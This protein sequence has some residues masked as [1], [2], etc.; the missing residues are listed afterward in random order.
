ML[1]SCDSN[2]RNYISSGWTRSAQFLVLTCFAATIIWGLSLGQ[3]LWKIKIDNQLSAT[4]I[5]NTAEYSFETTDHSSVSIQGII[6]P[7]ITRELKKYL[8][9]KPT[10]ELINLN[11]TGGNIFEARGIAKLIEAKKL[12]THVLENCF[13]SCTTVFIAGQKRTLAH[14]AK[15][16]FHQYRVNSNKLFAPNVN[17]KKELDKDIATFRKQG[18]SQT[19]LDRAFLR[20]HTDMWFPD[21]SDLIEA[22]VIN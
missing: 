12:N 3:L 5:K 7:G 16:G 19:F 9:L 10:I 8:S 15:L 20:P 1:R 21:H 14:N 4:E 6:N 11:S 17:V 2:I 13:S 18:V 22:G